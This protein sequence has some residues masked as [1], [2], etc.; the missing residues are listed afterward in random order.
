MV[1]WFTILSMYRLFFHPLSECAGPNLAAMTGWY[2][3]VFD[4]LRGGMFSKRIDELHKQYGN[5]VRINPWELHIRDPTFFDHFYTSSSKIDKDPWYYNFA[6]IFG[7]TFAT[8][9]ASIHRLRRAAISKAFATSPFTKNQI[10]YCVERLIKRLQSQQDAPPT[11][12]IIRMSD[13][14][15][16]LSSDIVTSCMMPDRTNYMVLPGRAPQY[17][18]MF[19]ALA[20]VALWNR[21]FPRVFSLLSTL[22]Q[23]FGK[24]FAQP[25]C[26]VLRMQDDIKDQII[27]AAIP[28]PDPEPKST[29][30]PAHLLAS[31]LS[32]CDKRT[33]RLLEEITMIIGAGTEA[34]G[35]ALS[36]TVYY[37]LS[38][39][40]A[41]SKVRNELRNAAHRQRPSCSSTSPLT[42]LQ[43]DIL[44][45][46]LLASQCPYLGAC[47]KEG[48]RLSKE[49][50][51]MPRISSLP[52][53]YYNPDEQKKYNIPVGTVV[54]M[55]LRDVHLHPSIFPSPHTF[56][57]E[58]WL[59]E[60]SQVLEKYLVPFA[61]GSRSCPGRALAME[62]LF[63]TVGN[64]FYHVDME[65]WETT[66]E[67]IIAAHDFF[68]GA[69]T[70][71]EG[72]L[73][74]VL[75]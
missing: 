17:A 35:A 52:M 40:D 69:T 74:I 13:L 36:I 12:K 57:P 45:Y 75:K 14:F 54:S 29:T 42:S 66:E 32:P 18:Q 2:E 26:E 10:E 62:E 34:V 71:R 46:H 3:T 16:M 25:L 44:P 19:K 30:L 70:E 4:C 11:H 55:S 41:V 23:C 7:S 33:T 59:G 24:K 49:S 68:S 53:T 9:S 60:S 37:L 22:P 73:K 15:W 65:L 43:L 27:Q 51:R 72:G 48:L 20:K 58:R 67:D 1:G 5:V 38:F 8:S 63:V 50:N 6:G 61:K 39:P 56:N 47:I 31:N 64:L 21:H 28:H